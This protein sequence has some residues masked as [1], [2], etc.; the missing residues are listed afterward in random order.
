MSCTTIYFAPFYC[1][2][3]LIATEFTCVELP[4]EIQDIAYI[5]WDIDSRACEIPFH[6]S[7]RLP[8]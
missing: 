4:V 1:D 8:M 2:K 5:K 7:R 3:H 6:V